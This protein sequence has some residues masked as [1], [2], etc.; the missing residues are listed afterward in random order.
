MAVFMSTAVVAQLH[1]YGSRPT[2]F[3][4]RHPKS[5]HL[6]IISRMI[7]K[8]VMFWIPQAAAMGVREA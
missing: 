4:R 8:F 5:A 7:R 6:G 1:R 3:P 2:P